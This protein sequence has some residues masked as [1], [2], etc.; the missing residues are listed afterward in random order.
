VAGG[1]AEIEEERVAVEVAVE[2]VVAEVAEVWAELKR[3]ATASTS[4]LTF[5]T[6]LTT[7]ISAGLLAI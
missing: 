4:L 2:L 3:N 7:Q 1:A 5:R 6:F